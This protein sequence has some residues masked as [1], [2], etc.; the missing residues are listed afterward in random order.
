MIENLG[1]FLEDLDYKGFEYAPSNV[2]LE[3]Q[4]AFCEGKNKEFYS[5]IDQKILD[6]V[7]RREEEAN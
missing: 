6:M 4:K 2:E 5:I 7:Q 1:N 3:Y